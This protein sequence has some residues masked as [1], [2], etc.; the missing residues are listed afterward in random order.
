M[1]KAKLKL[2]TL[3]RVFVRVVCQHCIRTPALVGT[4]SGLRV[5][6]FTKIK[7]RQLRVRPIEW[8]KLNFASLTKRWQLEWMAISVSCVNRCLA[9]PSCKAAYAR[10][11]KTRCP[12]QG[13]TEVL[14]KPQRRTKHLWTAAIVRK[15]VFLIQLLRIGSMQQSTIYVFRL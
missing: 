13:S 12:Q 10:K 7:K 11:G 15:R 9:L 6:D 5:N 14:R 3:P 4:P 1:G 8:L 2:T